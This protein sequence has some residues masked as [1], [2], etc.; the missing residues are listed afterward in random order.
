MEKWK[1]L[2]ARIDE[3]GIEPF[4]SKPTKISGEDL[5]GKAF[6]VSQSDLKSHLEDT[7]IADFISEEFNSPVD[8][9]EM[10]M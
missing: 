8:G 5:K 10:Q 2:W 7:S 4:T 6:D 3:L 9:Q 1:L